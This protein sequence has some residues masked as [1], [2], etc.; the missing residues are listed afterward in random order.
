MI[1]TK[2]ALPKVLNPVIT[3]TV[4]FLFRCAFDILISF[5]ISFNSIKLII[6]HKKQTELITCF[7]RAFFIALPPK[8]LAH[9]I[10]II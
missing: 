8:K 10:K 3:V 7:L 9:Y 6:L 4:F 2:W 5:S 1:F